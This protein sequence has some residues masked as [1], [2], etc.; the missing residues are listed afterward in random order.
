MLQPGETKTVT[1]PLTGRDLAYCD[2]PGKQW[3]A[4]AG[5]YEVQIGASSR[6]IRLTSALRLARTWTQA[7]P[8]LGS[9]TPVTH[10]PADLAFG[11]PALASASETAELGPENAVD[12]DPSTRWSS[13]FSDPQWIA[14]DLGKT[15]PVRRVRLTWEDAYATAYVI[16]VSPDGKTWKDVSA[17]ANGQGDM[18]TAD[19][20][21]TPAR[22]VR[23]YCM[24]RAT[25]FGD[26]LFSF[27]VFK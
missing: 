1:M 24:R 4:D 8:G 26:S 18:E 14:V 12:G 6:D 27:E 10:D 15:F 20:A 5:R 22:W 7:I 11:R 19:F 21:P 13:A 16:Q 23:V 9:G 17:Q 3:R 25:K 2:V